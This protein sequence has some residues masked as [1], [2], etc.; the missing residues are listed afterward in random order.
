MAVTGTKSESQNENF[1]V[2]FLIESSID[3]ITAFAGGGQ[4]GA[5]LL[6]GEVNRITTVASI[7][8]SVKLPPSIA[9]LSLI[10]INP[11]GKRAQVSRTSSP[12]RN[13]RC[14]PARRSPQTR[15]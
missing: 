5:I 15:S 8:D 9:G 11:R 3:N 12:H 13:D 1:K 6:G 7:G 4:A 14:D 10:V 2:G